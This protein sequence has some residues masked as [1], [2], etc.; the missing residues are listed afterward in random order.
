VP[1][2][3]PSPRQ[4]LPL[5]SAAP[6]P[7]APA[8]R[9]CCPADPPLRPVPR[10]HRSRQSHQPRRSRQPRQ[11]RSPCQSQRPC[12]SRQP[13]LPRHPRLAPLL[14]PGIRH[15]PIVQ[16]AV[17]RPRRFCRTLPLLSN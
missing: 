7:P 9:P 6:F 10:S 17:L 5:S 2:P 14:A 15:P 11:P 16:Q 12:C 13:Q 8:V 1:S 4:P 3:V